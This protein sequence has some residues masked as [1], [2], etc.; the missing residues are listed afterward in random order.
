MSMKIRSA[1]LDDAAAV[2]AILR[3][4][5]LESCVADHQGQ[6]ETLAAWLGNKTPETIA[7]WFAAPSNF[8]LVLE[9]DGVPVGV[10]LLN[11]AGKLSLCYLLPEAQGKGGGSCLLRGI[12]AQALVW[13]ISVIR[14]HSTKG[15]H[16]FF[17]RHGYIDGGKEKACYGVETDFFWKKLDAEAHAKASATARKRFC[18]CGG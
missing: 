1:S 7:A 18:G 2:C 11:Q 14:V 16:A 9:D 15:A 17:T 5:I 8:S 4:S 3:R 12:E 6:P 13:D 10:A